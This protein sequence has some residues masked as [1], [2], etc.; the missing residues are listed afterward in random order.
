MSYPIFVSYGDMVYIGLPKISG[1]PPYVI[2]NLM[3]ES[4][5]YVVVG[6]DFIDNAFP[7]IIYNSSRG[8]GGGVIS[9]GDS[10]Q[11]KML[12]PSGLTINTD[13]QYW[14]NEGND[15]LE[16]DEGNS[17]T[18]DYVFVLESINGSSGEVKYG[19]FFYIKNAEKEEYN[20]YTDPANTPNNKGNINDSSKTADST[21]SVFT[22]I[23]AGAN[24]ISSTYPGTNYIQ[25]QC[26]MGAVAQTNFCQYPPNSSACPSILNT[27]C[28]T[29]GYGNNVNDPFCVAR[30][31]P[32]PSVP[33]PSPSPSPSPPA[34]S[35]S[36][37]PS[38]SP[39][40]PSPS[41]SKSSPSPSYYPSPSPSYYPSPS[42]SPSY[43]PSPSPSLSYY[44]S[45]SP[46]QPSQPSRPVVSPSPLPSPSPNPSFFSDK[47]VLIGIAFI[48]VMVIILIAFLIYR[49]KK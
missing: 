1:N 24:A 22:F 6:Q 38:P 27:Y 31:T 36:P 46:S 17:S 18:E 43:Y 13:V 30:N 14:G 12:N 42:P 7:H 3:T 20:T 32:S 19:D 37:S 2:N 34:P 48:I 23:Y 4:D 41:P 39:P 29:G 8:T 21:N 26:C 47:Y 33:A 44:P 16:I 49:S 25:A 40:A 5:Y 15:E 10:I 28:G 11:V 45:P 35:P 9:Y